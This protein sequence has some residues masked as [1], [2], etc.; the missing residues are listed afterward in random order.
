MSGN[1]STSAEAVVKRIYSPDKCEDLYLKNRP[2]IGLLPKNEK[3]F[4]EHITTAVCVS[5]GQA[6]SRTA[7]RAFANVDLTG[8]MFERFEVTPVE[9]YE[10]ANVD[11]KTI[12]TTKNN[13]GAFVSMVK[14][15]GDNAIENIANNLEISLFGKTSGARGRVHADT[16]LDSGA[17]LKLARRADALKFE[18]GMELTVA[19]AESSG[20]E[21]ALGS[22]SHGLYVKGVNHKLGTLT[23]GE[24]PNSGADDV[25]SLDDAA[26]GIP[27]IAAGD[28]IFCRGDRNLAIAGFPAWLP[29]DDEDL[30]VEFFGVDRSAHRVRLAGHYHNG[31]NQSLG[32]ALEDLGS[33]ITT[34][35]GEVTLVLM[36][37][38]K[39]TALSKEIGGQRVYVDVESTKAQIGYRGFEITIGRRDAVVVPCWACPDNEAFMIDPDTWELDSVD[40]AVHI[41]QADGKMW[42]RDGPNSMG[43]RAYSLA[44][45]RCL[46]PRSNGRVKLAA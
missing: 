32:S 21:R 25:A 6:R 35:S 43:V 33:A 26:D 7:A 27:T 8:D 34:H 12:A 18:I 20:G 44:N 10:Y 41:W 5:P 16:V 15:I 46:D 37:P 22:N 30:T 39:V 1:N 23:I 24:L 3:A 36:A 14:K 17:T 11:N 13:V 2:A 19:A 42:L 9:D 28:W 40:K 31:T 45:L 4:G 29:D 38:S